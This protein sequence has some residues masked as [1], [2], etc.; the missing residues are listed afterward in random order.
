M[1][2]PELTKR[3]TLTLLVLLILSSCATVQEE[4]SADEHT[5]YASALSFSMGSETVKCAVTVRT[6][7]DG[8]TTHFSVPS[9]VI[10]DGVLKARYLAVNTPESTGKIEEWGK[11]AAL[12]TKE[13]LAGAE[14]IWIESDTSSWN[15]DSTGDRHLVWVWY[16]TGTD[17]EYR[18]LNLE[19]LQE[20]LALPS[21]SANNRYGS[22]CMA[23]IDQAKREKL[24]VWSG[25]KDPDFFYGDAVELTL[26]ELRAHIADYNGVKVAFEGNI[27]INSGN[28]VYSED[29]DPETGC[30]FAIPVY[31]GFSMNGSGLDI[32]SVGNRVRI[33]GTVQYYEG[34]ESWQV[35]GL[36]YRQMRPDDPSNIKLVRKGVDPVW[37]DVSLEELLTEEVSV[38]D[39]GVTLPLSQAV[40]ASTVTVRDLLVNDTYVSGD[41]LTLVCT[42]GDFETEIRVEARGVS[43]ADLKGRIVS[44][45]GI[46]D[47]WKG[48]LQI[49]VFRAEDLSVND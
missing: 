45:K 18:C 46:A 40:L 49:K 26:A 36:K 33:V 28:T 2:I 41:V 27:T 37:R 43:E 35:S 21:S 42:S 44:V 25:E 5:D 12:Y 4:A 34:G 6:F 14:S 16:R 30:V 38:G 23:A 9:E 8:D 32:L 20:G 7:I 10:P 48:K 11:R 24:C 3:L 1:R 17:E 31:Y 39:D 19:L 15:L 47:S 22:Y 13:K 29:V